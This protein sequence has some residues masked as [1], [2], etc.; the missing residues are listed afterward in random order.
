L[1]F[2]LKWKKKKKKLIFSLKWKKKK[3]KLIFE[4]KKQNKQITGLKSTH[5]AV[6]DCVG[7]SPQDG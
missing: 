1:I 4:L 6:G 2:S 3:K 7:Y 5:S